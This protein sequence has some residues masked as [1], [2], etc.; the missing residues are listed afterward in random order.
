MNAPTICASVVWV[1][2]DSRAVM[3]TIARPVSPIS[4]SVMVGPVEPGRLIQSLPEFW[5]PIDAEPCTESPGIAPPHTANATALAS[6]VCMNAAACA[7]VPA[8]DTT[9]RPAIQYEAKPAPVGD[10]RISSTTTPRSYVIA[11]TPDNTGK[12]VN[13]VPLYSISF[14]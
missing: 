5:S 13:V 1:S 6:A 8:P 11:S 7:A 9:G 14:S 4:T 2:T 3:I 10:Q 12:F